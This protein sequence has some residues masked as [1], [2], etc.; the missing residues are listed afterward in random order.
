MRSNPCSYEGHRV[1]SGGLQGHSIGDAYPFAVVGCMVVELGDRECTSQA[2]R[3]YVLDCSTGQRYVKRN[4]GR[5]F[6]SSEFAHRAARDLAD[7]ALHGEAGP[8]GVRPA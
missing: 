1:N 6:A 7:G 2:T 4:S 3:Y 5:T 8:F